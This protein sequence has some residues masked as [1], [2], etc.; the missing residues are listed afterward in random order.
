MKKLETVQRLTDWLFSN[1]FLL[2]FYQI[3][4]RLLQLH[5][6]PQH[7]ST[8]FSF[9]KFKPSSRAHSNHA[10]LNS[11]SISCCPFHRRNFS[12]FIIWCCQ[13][14]PPQFTLCSSHKL[15]IFLILSVVIHWSRPSI[16]LCFGC[17]PA[18][19][20][21]EQSKLGKS[22]GR[23]CSNSSSSSL[24]CCPSW[25]LFDHLYFFPVV[26]LDDDTFPGVP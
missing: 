6:S 15:I 25:V 18:L 19:P 24:F 3:V 17:S 11:I 10:K 26:V 5:H 12:S 21:S 23:C 9:F 14:L 1:T 7:N 13:S 8:I 2:L 20:C 4:S 16:L 22:R